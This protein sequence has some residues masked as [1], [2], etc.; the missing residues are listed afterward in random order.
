LLVQQKGERTLLAE[1]ALAIREAALAFFA[2][3]NYLPGLRNT[4]IA[5]L[6][7]FNQLMGRFRADFRGLSHKTMLTT[8][9]HYI[10]HGPLEMI[11]GDRVCVLLGCDRPLAIRPTTNS[12]M[13]EVVGPVMMYGV[14]DGE[15][16]RQA[17]AGK[18]EYQEL[19]FRR[20]PAE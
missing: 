16:I 12:N 19:S 7:D 3:N 10:G 5:S 20:E 18:L 9:K 11:N 6:D 13:Y 14:H 2:D 15:I 8:E 1:A 4:K 17:E